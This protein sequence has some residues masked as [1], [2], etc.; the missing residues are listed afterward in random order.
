MRNSVVQNIQK[1]RESQLSQ[2]HYVQ[3][4]IKGIK[5]EEDQ[6]NKSQYDCVFGQWLFG[7]GEKLKAHVDATLI[8]EVETLHAIWHEEYLKIYQIFFAKKAGFLTKFL[9][10][11]IEISAMDSDRAK[12]YLKD[13]EDTTK[14]LVKKLD[15]IMRKAGALGITSLK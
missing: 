5:L 4:L 15:V 13:L 14:Q 12:I 11:E 2:L 8:D 10:K 9:G 1:A 3:L 6:I 7:E